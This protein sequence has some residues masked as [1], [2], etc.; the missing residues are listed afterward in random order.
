MFR[1]PFMFWKK[2]PFARLIIFF[3]AGII[4][5]WYLQIPVRFLWA[6]AGIAFFAIIPFSFSSLVT[7]FRFS[8]L[9]GLCFYLLLFFTGCILACYSDIQHH[10][11]WF[12]KMYSENDV[13]IARLEEPL[14]EKSKS[15]KAVASITGLKNDSAAFKTNG[16]IIIY[17]RKDSLLPAL[18]YGSQLL[19]KKKLQPVRNSGN[20]GGFD[21]R[22]YCHFED[23]SHQVFLA[24]KD[25]AVL[26]V[27]DKK[28]LKDFIYTTREKVVGILKK[29]IPGK[30]EQGLAEALLIGYKDDL[31]KKLVQA[32]S[33]TGVVHI[34]AISGLH[35]GIIYALLALLLQPLKRNKS[36][37]W[38]YPVIII[39]ALW[40]F[41]LLAGAQPSVL[42]S[43]VMFTCIV[44]GQAMSRKVSIYNTLAFSAFLLLCYNPFWLWDVGFQ[45]SYAAVLSIVL[46][47]QPIYR[48][49]YI[50]NKI[51]DFIWKLNAVTIAAQILTIPVS[52]YHFHQFP[53][54]FL[55]TNFLAVP[56]SSLILIGEIL[57]CAFA[58]LPVVADFLGKILYQMIDAMNLWVERIDNLP[59]AILDNIQISIPQAVLLLATAAGIGYWLME[60]RKTGLQLGLAALL[61]FTLIRSFSFFK[62]QQQEKIIVYN[63]PGHSGIDFV[64]GRTYYFTGDS[65]L[66]LDDFLRNFHIKPSRIR[67]R[68]FP[69]NDTNLIIK[70]GNFF[71]FENKKIAVLRHSLKSEKAGTR[72][73]VDLLVLSGNPRIYFSDLIHWLDIK[74]VVFDGSNAAWKLYFWKK[75]CD[76]LKI[77]YHDV[78]E[79]GAFVMTLN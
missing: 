45:L 1:S 62:A 58:S 3:A 77:P 52:I 9:I 29:Y 53:N 22:Q 76:S 71:Q 57:L 32:Y 36:T 27:T 73:P 60:K 49:F 79:N 64:K 50:K 31:D 74:Q 18:G 47:F 43:A 33:N 59:F 7:R 63:I 56:L 70:K 38:L 72:I 20:P 37:N 12:G 5:Q 11:R 65:S 66:L 10:P 2:A 61:L 28:L 41:G 75:D 4:V 69:G 21:Y 34:I 26:P 17:F 51:L 42:R 16:R 67:Y 15:Y 54:Y 35:L 39:T 78:S 30:K 25:F 40:L 23:I 44:A 14:S 8:L 48:W 46:F 13:V 55:L 24:R 6:G 19:F 68:V